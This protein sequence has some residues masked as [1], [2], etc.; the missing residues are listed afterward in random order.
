MGSAPTTVAMS[1]VSDD[2]DMPELPPLAYLTSLYPAVSHTFIQREVLKLRQAGVQ[3][4][5]FTIRRAPDEHLLSP[6]DRSEA[7]RTE[8]VLPVS[9][10]QLIGAHLRALRRRPVSASRKTPISG[11]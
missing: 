5:T 2:S 10:G 6:V 1:A 4:E 8:S 11:W 3:V 7:D 9:A